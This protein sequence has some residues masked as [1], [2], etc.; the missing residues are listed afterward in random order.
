[1][2]WSFGDDSWDNY[3]NHKGNW[4]LYK[5]QLCQENLGC[6]R[7]QIYIDAKEKFDTLM[8]KML[9]VDD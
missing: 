6:T 8:A 9:K 1:M 3:A 4:C 7:C 2:E 5:S